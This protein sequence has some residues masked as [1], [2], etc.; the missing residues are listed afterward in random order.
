MARNGT[1]DNPI[2]ERYKAQLEAAIEVLKVVDAYG[3][4]LVSVMLDTPSIL[5]LAAKI[6]MEMIVVTQ[7]YY[8]TDAEACMLASLALLSSQL[9]DMAQA[10][11]SEILKDKGTLQ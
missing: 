2:Q 7:P 9:E 4:M 1:M 5:G 8:D 10:I 11:R 6:K 3:I